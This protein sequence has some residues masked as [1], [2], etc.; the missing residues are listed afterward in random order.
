MQTS[1]VCTLIYVSIVE[2]DICRNDEKKRIK[3]KR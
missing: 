3:D 2:K 1:N